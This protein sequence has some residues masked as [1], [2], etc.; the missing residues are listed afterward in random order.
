M[1]SAVVLIILICFLFRF[2]SSLKENQYCGFQEENDLM[3][4]GEENDNKFYFSGH[5]RLHA[6]YVYLAF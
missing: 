1:L 4:Q 5:H 3:V 6:S 2:C